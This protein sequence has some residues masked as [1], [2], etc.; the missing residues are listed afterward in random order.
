MADGTYRFQQPG[1]GQ[2][3]F[4]SQQQHSHPRHL[5]NG[6]NSPGRLKLSNETPSPSRSPSANQSA[7]L[8]RFNMYQAH[9]TQHVMMNGAQAHQ[10][11]GMQIPKFQ[12]QNHHPH[13]ATQQHHLNHHPQAGHSIAHQHFSGAGLA[14]T[15]PHFTPSHLQNGASAAVDDDVDETNEY[16]QEQRQLGNEARQAN[17]PHYHAR[18]MASQTRGIPVMANQTDTP[19]KGLDAR[20]GATSNKLAPRPGLSGIDC[21]GQGMRALAPS[22]FHN[23]M[24]LETLHLSYNK[25]KVLPPQIGQLRKLTHLDLTGNEISE[26]PEEIG[27]LTNLQTLVLVDNNIRNLPFEMGYLYRLDKLVVPGNP[28]NDILKAQISA[29]GTKGLVKYLREEMPG[30]LIAP[31]KYTGALLNLVPLSS[32]SST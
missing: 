7:A 8:N 23:F 31:L 3:Y 11:F 28:L 9:G 20:A 1:A 32:S 13:H 2:F 10:R 12:S 5:Q 27:M 6:T 18:L 25:L 14:S 22:L 19:E 26:L 4:Q 24:F 29:G 17:S 15:T 30:K 21:G 16:W